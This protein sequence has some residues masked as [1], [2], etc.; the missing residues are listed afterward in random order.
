MSISPRSSVEGRGPFPLAT[1]STHSTNASNSTLALDE[2]DASIQAAAAIPTF[3]KDGRRPIEFTAEQKR[4]G[5]SIVTPKAAPEGEAAAVDEKRKACQAGEAVLTA[6]LKAVEVAE[7]MLVKAYQA[8]RTV[9]AA[10]D[11]ALEVEK[12]GGSD[13]NASLSA[14]NAYLQA[15]LIA[16]RALFESVRSVGAIGLASA[17]AL[18]KLEKSQLAAQKA[19]SA[20]PQNPLVPEPTPPEQALALERAPVTPKAAP[21]SANSNTSEKLMDAAQ[22]GESN[23]PTP[24]AVT[25]TDD[26]AS[27]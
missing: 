4:D 20:A 17:E 2:V 23:P 21:P 6:E 27:T 18:C 26:P 1:A 11:A 16:D 24:K 9:E 19:A 7:A 25:S 3:D 22:S 8:N 12:Q 10:I 15:A 14:I 5:N 13:P